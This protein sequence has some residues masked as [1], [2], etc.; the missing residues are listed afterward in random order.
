M[1]RYRKNTDKQSRAVGYNL[2]GRPNNAV[3]KRAFPPGQHGRERKKVSEYGLQLKEKQKIKWYYGLLE[4]QFYNTFLKAT[5]RPGVTG[6]ILLQLLES[7]FDN[8]L[9]RS[10]LVVTRRQGRQLIVHGHLLINGQK[11]DRPSYVMKPGDIITVRERSRSFIK[12]LQ[13]GQN[14]IV[15]AWIESDLEHL[16][17]K[18][19]AIPSREDIDPLFQENLVVEFY[20]R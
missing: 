14:P 12:A 1:A 18:V 2:T 17:A 8:V 16:S 7:R 10:G 4:K 15:P 11:V 20:S 6:T 5:H 13:E 9:F 3:I 19:L